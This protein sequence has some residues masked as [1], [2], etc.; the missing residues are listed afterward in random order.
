MRPD[1]VQRIDTAFFWS[2]CEAGELRVQKCEPCNK[3]WHPPR[4]MC[5]ECHSVEKTTQKLSGRGKIL[6]WV[7]QVR[8][9]SFGFEDSPYVILV[10]L[11]EGLRLVSNFVGDG[12]PEFGMA[13]SVDFAQK[14]GKKAVP[15]FK[16]D[17]T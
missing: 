2:A 3:L 12:K 10:E 8:P 17:L 1:P 4:P 5:P 16:A 7:R 13:V 6:S 15:V 9:A 14:S 11:A